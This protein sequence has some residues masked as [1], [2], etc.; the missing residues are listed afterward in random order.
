[1]VEDTDV[2]KVRTIAQDVINV[3]G[4]GITFDGWFSEIRT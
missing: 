2:G 3:M 4:G 1:M